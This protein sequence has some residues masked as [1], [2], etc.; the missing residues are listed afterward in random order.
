VFLL[1]TPAVPGR[2]KLIAHSIREVLNI[3]LRI[4]VGPVAK[5]DASALVA[6]FA[7]KWSPL[8]TMRAGPTPTTADITIPWG[9][10]VRIDALVEDHKRP[11]ETQFNR[12]T[13]LFME[14]QIAPGADPESFRPQ[15]KALKTNHDWFVDIAHEEELLDAKLIDAEFLRRAE[16]FEKALEGFATTSDFF[17]AKGEIDAILAEANG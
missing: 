8:S 4:M 14:I 16:V 9:V 15:A 10:A 2:G 1:E 11:L 3:L 12:I 6:K 17:E 5:R 13:A 7:K